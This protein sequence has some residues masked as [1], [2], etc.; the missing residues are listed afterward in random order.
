MG[1]Y[2]ET[3]FTYHDATLY[4]SDLR[5]LDPGRWLNDH[6]IVFRLECERQPAPPCRA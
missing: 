6:C 4:Q 5:L 3:L 1:G 2:G